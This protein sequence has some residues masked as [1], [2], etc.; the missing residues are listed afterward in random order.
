LIAQQEQAKTYSQLKE[1]LAMTYP[2]D[3]ESYIKGKGI[4]I[5]EVIDQAAIV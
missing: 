3:V 1:K 2:N 4:C 5:K